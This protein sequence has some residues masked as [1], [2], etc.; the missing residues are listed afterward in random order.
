MTSLIHHVDEIYEEELPVPI[1][2]KRRKHIRMKKKINEVEEDQEYMKQSFGAD[3]LSHRS[4]VNQDAVTSDKLRALNILM[5]SM[6][7]Q[8]YT[9]YYKA[10]MMWHY[11]M[12]VL[13]RCGDLIKSKQE[14]QKRCLDML[15]RHSLVCVE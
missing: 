12:L 8:S 9:N 2:M 1:A 10:F 11:S 7:K 3:E 15:N 5:Y 13:Q 6:A 4:S 14:I